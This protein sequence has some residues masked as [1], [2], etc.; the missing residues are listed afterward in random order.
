MP[1]TSSNIIAHF[2]LDS[3]FVSVELLKAPSLKGKAVIV[4]GHHERGIVTT[5]SYEARK[6]GVHSAMP[7]KTAMRLCPHAVV[8][9]G[10]YSEYTRY[11]KWVTQIIASKAPL[12]E[13]ASIDEFYIDLQ[14]MDQFFNP[15]KWTIEL[16]ELIINETGLPI[17]FGIAKNKMVAK[18]ATNE[19]KPNG[20]LQVLLGKEKEF[21]APLEVNKIP[22]VG[23][24][25]SRILNYHGIKLIKDIHNTTPE[26]LEKLLGKWGFE[27][28]N[29]AQGNHLST[30]SEYREQK[31]ISKEN[32][33]EENIIDVDFL[34]SEIVRMTE[35]ISFE[36]RKEEKVAGCVTIKLRYPNFETTSRQA[37]IPYTSADD[38]IIPVAKDIFHK[39]YRQGN[40][41]R[42]LGVRLSDLTNDAVQ[43]NL[44]QDTERKN[45][46][47]KAIDGVKNRF[48]NTSVYRASGK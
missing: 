13:K 37:S 6:F 26:N 18:M 47:Y 20:F 23:E 27:L 5:C 28:W 14:G 40:P 39:L 1:E 4:G 12:F 10:T 21:L 32:T 3:F 22:G 36:L 11:S 46:L 34:M 38:E 35:R 2:D 24:Q 19:A 8:I 7:M 29:K 17:S 25:T 9:S 42:L 31:S 44:F 16:R 48:G 30:I 41:V 43:T 45:V 33:F 15:L